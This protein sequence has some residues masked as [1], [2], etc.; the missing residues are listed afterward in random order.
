MEQVDQFSYYDLG[1][2]LARLRQLL[3]DSSTVKFGN[4]VFDM[5][6]VQTALRTFASR[7][8]FVHA[9]SAA[10]DLEGRIT[11]CVNASRSAEPDEDGRRSL[12]FEAQVELWRISLIKSA[13]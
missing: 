7:S 8:P 2:R 11:D 5:F 12:N 3:P 4:V 13:I 6:Q 9:R 10:S 1:S